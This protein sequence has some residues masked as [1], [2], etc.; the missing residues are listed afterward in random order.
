MGNAHPDARAAADEITGTNDDD[1]VAKV[2][3]RWWG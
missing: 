3:E 2:L 1:G